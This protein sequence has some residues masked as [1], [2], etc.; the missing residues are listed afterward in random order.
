M[1]PFLEKADARCA[2]HWSLK[3]IVSAFSCCAGNFTDCPVH[4]QL[5][6]ASPIH[7]QHDDRRRF[8]AAS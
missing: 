8:L 1:C 4:Q 6:A 7:E 3:N 5:S 2:D